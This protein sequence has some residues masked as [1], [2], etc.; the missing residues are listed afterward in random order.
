M[1]RQ[2]FLRRLITKYGSPDDERALLWGMGGLSATMQADMSESQLD[3][4]LILE[5][6]SLKDKADENMAQADA[7]RSAPDAFGF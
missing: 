6:V 7:K 4:T 1:R 3:A 2:E 5:D